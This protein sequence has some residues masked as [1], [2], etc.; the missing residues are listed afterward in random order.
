MSSI[1]SRPL[2]EG[3]AGGIKWFECPGGSIRLHFHFY[4]YRNEALVL[5]SS[6]IECIFR[7][8]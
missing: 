7:R 1:G 2:E 8:I 4:L 5:L 3:L 6:S